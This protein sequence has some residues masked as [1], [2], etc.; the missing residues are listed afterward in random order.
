MTTYTVT[1]GYSTEVTSEEEHEDTP[2]D[3]ALFFAKS[4]MNPD[5]HFDQ[6]MTVSVS[7]SDSA[8][9]TRTETFD[10]LAR[11]EIRILSRS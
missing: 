6:K 2:E 7:Y 1:N 9:G 11:V 4:N 5:N 10:M 8:I 3:A